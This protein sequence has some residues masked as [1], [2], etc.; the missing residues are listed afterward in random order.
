MR[1]FMVFSLFAWALLTGCDGAGSPNA[2]PDATVRT[3]GFDGPLKRE[4]AG[5]IFSA[6]ASNN[7]IDYYVKGTGPNNPVGGSLS[8]SLASPEGMA[9]DSAGDLYV[10]NTEDKNVLVYARGSNSPTATLNDPGEF[11][12]DVAVA[13]DGTVYVA[14]VFGPM[15]APGNVVIYAPGSSSPTKTLTNKHFN[16]VIGVALDRNG[17]LF[18]SCNGNLGSG[19]GGVVE[20]KSGSVEGRDTHISLHAAGGVGFDRDG[21]LVVIDQDAATLNVYD[22]GNPKPIHQ[23]ALPGDAY[24]FAFNKESTRVYVAD[25]GLSE[26][27]VFRYRPSALTL[28]NKITNGI[29]ASSGNIGI[30]ATPAQQL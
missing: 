22:I 12:A 15:F 18:V 25:Y 21:H 6:L 2:A 27:D 14:N 29:S 23:L 10:A 13:A 11:P 7:T 28:V 4:S 8:G 17:N 16:H 9:T 19:S 20:F 3:S 30:A 26:I 1:L 5:L 24:Y